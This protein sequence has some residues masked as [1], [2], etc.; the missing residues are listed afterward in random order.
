[1]E[2]LL[3]PGSIK[4]AITG[5]TFLTIFEYLAKLWFDTQTST[6]WR[7]V[8]YATNHHATDQAHE[9]GLRFP[10]VMIG[11]TST[12]F[13]LGNFF[14]IDGQH[15]VQFAFEPSSYTSWMTFSSGSW[16]RMEYKQVAIPGSTN[17]KYS[18]TIN[19]VEVWSKASFQ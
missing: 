13:A 11:A 17:A 15:D 4:S 5:N 2:I 7:T 8:L 19:D 10:A 9:C 1:M 12:D 3:I 16:H 18:I 6:K 14:C